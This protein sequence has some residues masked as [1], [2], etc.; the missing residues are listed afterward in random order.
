MTFLPGKTI[1]EEAKASP[2][3]MS[4]HGLQLIISTGRKMQ[5]EGAETSPLFMSKNQ[6]IK[7]N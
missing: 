2:A 3:F 6:L 4:K 1:Q 5:E 7:K